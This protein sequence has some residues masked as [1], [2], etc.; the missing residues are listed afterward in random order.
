MIRMKFSSVI[1]CGIPH[2]LKTKHLAFDHQFPNLSQELNVF[3]H[4]FLKTYV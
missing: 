3:L 1:P 4:V 2:A